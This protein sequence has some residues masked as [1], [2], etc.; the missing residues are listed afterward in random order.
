MDLTL[1]SWTGP[2]GY[3]SNVEDPTGLNI[4]TYTVIVTAANGCTETLSVTLILL[5]QPAPVI[6]PASGGSTVQCISSATLPTPPEATDACGTP[7]TPVLTFTVDDPDPL[8]CEGTR[9]Y[10]FTY[11]D[12]QPKSKCR[13]VY[14]YTIDHSTAPAEV[15][16]PV[17]TTGGSVQ[18]T[19]AAT[20]PTILPVVQDVC[21]AELTPTG[22]PTI[23]GT[24]TG[25]EGTYTFTYNYLDC[26]GLTLSWT[27]TYTIDHTTAPVLP[28]NGAGTVE[29]L[30]SAVPPL[31]G[32]PNPL[33]QSQYPLGDCMFKTYMNSAV[34]DQ[35]QLS[36]NNWILWQNTGVGL[37]F[38][39]AI[40]EKLT[41]V[42]V[43][44]YTFT[45]T[46]TFLLE[47][48]AGNGKTGTPL[49]SAGG[50]SIS[51]TNWVS[52]TL[53]LAT[54]PTLVAGQQYTF[55]LTPYPYNSVQLRISDGNNLYPGGMAWDELPFPT[56]ITDVCGTVIPTPVPG[57]VTTYDGCE[58]TVVYTYT[59][60]DCSGLST[61]WVY[62]LLLITPLHRLFLFR[63]KH[64]SMC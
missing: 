34:A 7:I 1:T 39:P 62:T 48:Y 52:L 50:Y 36:Y 64:R 61:N 25:C 43:N 14:T 35:E 12:Y 4:G 15:G 32:P 20:A 53:P 63:R 27:Y 26:A 60:A 38:T 45:G 31:A 33:I 59:Y 40:T 37:S 47:V 55:W 16:G 3:I 23:G 41:Q 5:E 58:G 46:P 9:T 29:C 49:Y 42:D 54:A 56:A 13:W 8:T 21:G 6:T 11:T 28:P 10:T 24:Y 30:T 44:V 2:G 57:V 51:S 18:C 17:S 19:S 22:P